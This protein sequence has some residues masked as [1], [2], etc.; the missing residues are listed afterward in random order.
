MKINQVE[1]I[2]GITKKNIRFYEEQG[3]LSPGRNRENGY[4]E[5]SEEDVRSLQQIKLMRKPGIP[6]EE[7]RSMQ[8]G[9]S[10][11][12]D[13]M[14]RHLVTIDRERRNLEQS[15]RF[16]E[17]LKEQ[18]G[19]IADLDAEALLAEMTSLERDGTSFRDIKVRDVRRM[20][21]AGAV[22]ASAVMIMLMGALFSLML[23][24][25]MTDAE[26][27][28]PF[29]LAVLLL[30]TPVAVAGGVVLAL[31]QRIGEIKKGEADDAREF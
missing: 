25:F 10:T 16:C 15:A 19:L 8:S 26:E 29:F 12:A 27:A 21:Y 2:V 20:R 6:I 3:L 5:Y 9:K 7:I 31:V 1:Q 28:P 13:G 30:C 17:I 22:G 14:R 24:A 23:W 4:R 11:V 18:E